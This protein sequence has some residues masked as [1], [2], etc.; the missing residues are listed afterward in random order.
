ME[1]EV[2][3]RLSI[4]VLGAVG[5]GRARIEWIIKML[6]LR[7]L[8]VLRDI[9]GIVISVSLIDAGPR[10]ST[11]YSCGRVPIKSIPSCL[12]FIIM[13]KVTSIL[14]SLNVLPSSGRRSWFRL[15]GLIYSLSRRYL[16]IPLSSSCCCSS[17]SCFRLDVW[18]LVFDHR[19]SSN[20]CALRP[21]GYR[22]AT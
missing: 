18:R 22:I 2:A 8:L 9:R 15:L 6:W 1:T 10:A 7:D 14:A 11:T 17:Y 19:R 3:Y 16:L 13:I 21:I 20:S 5:I 12:D 4:R